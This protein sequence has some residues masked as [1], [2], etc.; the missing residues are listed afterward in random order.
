L[1]PSRRNPHRLQPDGGRELQHERLFSLDE[2]RTGLGV[3][4]AGKTAAKRVNSTAYPIAGFSDCARRSGAFEI[5]RRRKSG[6][7]G[8]GN[9]DMFS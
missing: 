1:K 9:N 4:S 8:P 7:P 3:H 5:A 6:E 2:I